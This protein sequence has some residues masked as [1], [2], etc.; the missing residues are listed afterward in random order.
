MQGGLRFH[1]H[2]AHADVGATLRGHLEVESARRFCGQANAHLLAIDLLLAEELVL[3]PDALGQ[4][5]LAEPRA[6][7]LEAESLAVQVVTVG[8]R[9]VDFNRVVYG[10]RGEAER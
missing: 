1:R 9:E 4:L 10:T 3:V 5:S 8:D 7:G 6:D 2:I